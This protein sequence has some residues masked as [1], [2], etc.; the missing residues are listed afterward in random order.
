MKQ[1]LF[2]L[3]LNNKMLAATFAKILD[4]GLDCLPYPVYVWVIWVDYTFNK[5][6]VLDFLLFIKTNN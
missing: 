5:I 6:Y 1:S 3:V 4:H 2:L